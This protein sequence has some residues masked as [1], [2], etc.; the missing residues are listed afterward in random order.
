MIPVPLKIIKL[1][2]QELGPSVG[3][4]T[5]FYGEQAVE[6]FGEEEGEDWEDVNDGLNI[7]G[8]SREGRQS[9]LSVWSL[10]LN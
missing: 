3:E 9:L 8:M 10:G 1:L 7:P 5:R 2:V 6:E 4:N